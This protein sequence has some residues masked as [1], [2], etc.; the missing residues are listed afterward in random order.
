MN[1]ADLRHALVDAAQ[2]TQRLGLNRGTSGNLSVRTPGGLLVT[3]TGIPYDELVPAALVWMDPDGLP[4][5]GQLKPSSEWRF[6]RDILAAR[7]EAG[8]IVHTHSTYATALACLREDLPAF[9]YMI[10]LAGGNSVRCAPYALFGTAELSAAAVQALEGRQACLLAN[11]GAIALGSTVPGALRLAEELE[12][13]A[14]QYLAARS[15]GTPAL[16]SAQEMHQVQASFADYGRQ[17]P[18]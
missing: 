11:H 12:A 13:L 2:A 18:P 17:T 5:P 14:K 4:A 7:P 8:A 6:H 10:A 15:C 1:F 16:L 9:H 3:P